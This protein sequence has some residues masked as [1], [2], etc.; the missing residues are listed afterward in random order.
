M[1][2]EA[3]APPAARRSGRL[4]AIAFVLLLL[5]VGAGAA[6][7][8]FAYYPTTPQYAA[9]QFLD[10]A[11]ARDYETVYA[12]INMPDLL[13][14][15]VPNGEAFRRVVET[16]PAAFPP[17]ASYTVN[18]VTATAA[19]ATVRCTVTTRGAELTP[20]DIR[21]QQV[22][23]RWRIDGGWLAATMARNGGAELFKVLGPHLLTL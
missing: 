4:P 23:G 12:A 8:W 1:T 15:V 6:I 3:D 7:W 19:E 21:L 22:N 17:I 11:R 9:A 16:V 14:R 20:L 2:T 18:D 13:K 5:I 10:A